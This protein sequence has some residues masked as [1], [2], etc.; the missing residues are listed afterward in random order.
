MTKITLRQKST[1]PETIYILN[2]KVD[3]KIVEGSKFAGHYD[4]V[5]HEIYLNSS[6]GAL[7]S[8]LLHE[9]MEYIASA[10]YL[11]HYDGNSR[12]IRM[13]HDPDLHIDV[14]SPFVE[15]LRQTI[16]MN[17]LKDVIF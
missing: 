17:N 7:G 13:A 15:I 12:S 11:V 5:R 6:S 3:I 14:W 4:V 9:I 10:L 1:I 8:T 16:A 2:D